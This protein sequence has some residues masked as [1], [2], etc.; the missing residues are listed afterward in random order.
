ML[1]LWLKEQP[2][3]RGRVQG[4]DARIRLF[5]DPDTFVG[6]DI[7]YINA[8][9]AA[10]N[11]MKAPFIDEPPVLVV[12]ITSPS[13]TAEGTAEKIRLYL[14][15]G[16]PLVW[17]VNP[18]FRTVTVY[19]PDAP[20][21]LFNDTQHLTAEPHLPGF[22]SARGGGLRGLTP[23]GGKPRSTRHIGLRFRSS[24][25]GH[26][27]AAF[28][29]GK[30][31]CVHPAGPGGV[32]LMPLCRNYRGSGSTCSGKSGAMVSHDRAGPRVGKAVE[33]RSRQD[34]AH[35]A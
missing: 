32:M 4:G 28:K 33:N 7:A 13:D 22:R 9:Q 20:P 26:T 24:I 16:V 23:R 27:R 34:P 2:K 6:A 29:K 25:F 15:A 35:G 10:R 21:A 11:P 3:P 8:D 19:R 30:E 1:R 18:F 17:E 12:E 14:E 5:R 31:G